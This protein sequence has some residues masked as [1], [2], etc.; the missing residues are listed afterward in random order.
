MAGSTADA[1]RFKEILWSMNKEQKVFLTSDWSSLES[2]S[3]WM[4]G[5]IKALLDMT[6]LVV[7]ITTEEAL[8]NP[9]IHFEVG[10]AIGR[11]LKPKVFV[12]G[13]ID[14]SRSAVPPLSGLQLISTG[15]TN[16]WITDLQDL[17]Y[18]VGKKHEEELGKLF[19][20]SRD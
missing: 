19:K 12:F 6:H 17:G 20:Q 8:K 10:A 2:G 13:G 11:G 9:W 18:E 7:L 16:R 15:N 4:D 1:V 5:I 3:L 14:I